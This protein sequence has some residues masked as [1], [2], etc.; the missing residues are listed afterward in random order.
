ME[1]KFL[2]SLEWRYATKVFDKNKKISEND[3]QTLLD[4]LVL[5][6]SSFWLQPWRFLLIEN[7]KLREELKPNSWNQNQI[8]DASHLLVFARIDWNYDEL[9]ENYLEK[10]AEKR[11]VTREDIKGY[12]DMMK[13]YALWKWEEWMKKW[14]DEQVFIALGN[15]LTVLAEMKIDSCAIW[16]FD[17]NKYDEILGLKEK[18]LAS[19]IVLPIW[20]RDEEA[21][22]YAKLKKVRF[23]KEDLVIKY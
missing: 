15:A 3:L 14:A 6:S 8:T 23:E 5:T 7:D 9:I 20:Y 10:I 21:D 1:N 16:W 18:G 4:A 2:E 12:E 17:S 11:G 19:V 13:N 22:K